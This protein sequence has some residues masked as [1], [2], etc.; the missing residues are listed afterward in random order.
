MPKIDVADYT[1]LYRATRGMKPEI[2][3]AFRK[4]LRK[5]AD[6]GARG[7]KVKIR[8]MPATRKYTAT[9][10]G[11]HVRGKTA[12]G[13][14]STLATNIH[15]QVTAREVAIRQFSTGIKGRNAQD[16]PRDIDRGDWLH[17][18]FGHEP[19]VSQTGWPYFM[20]TMR[21]KRPE[22]EREV[23]KVLDDVKAKIIAGKLH[24]G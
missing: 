21:E 4:R 22:M 10:A 13:L 3:S 19:E 6:I 14:R 5:A 11:R 12:R 8:A 15:V 20:A 7:A 23:R 1:Q 24:L 16:L 17:P 2:R 18:T 9:G